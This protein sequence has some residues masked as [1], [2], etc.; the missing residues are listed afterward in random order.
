MSETDRPE[1][2][3]VPV[4][5]ESSQRVMLSYAG[6][7]DPASRKVSGVSNPASLIVGYLA[8]CSLVTWGFLIAVQLH[9]PYARRQLSDAV[10]SSL[11]NKW[12]LALAT[13]GVA[14][15]LFAFAVTR[16]DFPAF[17]P[18]RKRP[19]WL[20]LLGGVAHPLVLIV[21]GEASLDFGSEPNFF[22]ML[23]VPLLYF[24]IPPVVGILISRQPLPAK[25]AS[26]SSE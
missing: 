19:V 15:I 14:T 8:G 6:P 3:E 25:P 17:Q 5:Q 26:D 23:L 22:G 1:S 16:R 11:M 7:L 12:L 13:A 18:P 20:A 4:R 24:A 21:I 2:P 9:D 10:F